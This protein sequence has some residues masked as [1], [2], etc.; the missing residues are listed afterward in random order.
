M[1]GHRLHDRDLV[2]LLEGAALVLFH[3]AGAAEGDEGGAVDEGMGEAGGEIDRARPG[4]ADAE[5]RTR[6]HTR[7]GIGHHCGGLLVADVDHADADGLAGLDGIVAR[8]TP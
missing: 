4:G 8:A 3:G 1:F 2:D 6:P 7:V 5:A